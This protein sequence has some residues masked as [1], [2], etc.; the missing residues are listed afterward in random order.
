M[1]LPKMPKNLQILFAAMTHLTEV[2]FLSSIGKWRKRVSL[3]K[4]KLA[5]VM[6]YLKSMPT[7]KLSPDFTHDM[8]KKVKLLDLLRISH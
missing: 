5:P 2:L 1:F 8:K 4:S 3:Q 7:R 6:K